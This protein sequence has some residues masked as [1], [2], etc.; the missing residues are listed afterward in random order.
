VEAIERAVALDPGNV[1]YREQRLRFVR[2]LRSEARQPKP[3][4][5]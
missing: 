3:P 5:D 1:H 4:A 2:A